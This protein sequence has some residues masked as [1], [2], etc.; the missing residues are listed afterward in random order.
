VTSPPTVSALRERKRGGVAV[1]LDGRAWRVLPADAVVRAGLVVGRQ[2][3]RETARELGRQVRRAR[4]LAAAT[5]SLSATD[6]STPD[7]EQRLARAGYSA[8]ARE[9]AIASLRRAG[10]LDDSRVAESRARH[11]ARRG[12]GD[13][14]IRADLARRLIPAA[15]AAEAI[16]ALESE[17]QRA[18]RL[19]AGESLTPA[20]VRRLSARGFSRDTVEELTASVALET[21]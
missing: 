15:A 9:E 13:A 18:R 11:L 19:L 2:L 8:A 12:Y 7:L 20:V 6:R 1:E 3:D 5:R 17:F 21:S 10:L 16:A 14:A 4:A